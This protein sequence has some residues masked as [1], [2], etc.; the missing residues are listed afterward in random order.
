M[1]RCLILLILVSASLGRSLAG[2]QTAQDAAVVTNASPVEARKFNEFLGDVTRDLLGETMVT[3]PPA[4][5]TSVVDPSVAP[6]EL[7]DALRHSQNWVSSTNL[8]TQAHVVNDRE[9]IRA[10]QLKIEMARRHRVERNTPFAVS[11]LVSVLQAQVPDELK[12]TAL[13]ELALVAQQENQFARAQQIFA[14]YIARYPEDPGVPEVLLRQGLLFRQMGANNLALS[15]FYGVMTSA[16]N[17]KLDRLAYYQRLVLQAQAEIADTY[18]LE[19]EFKDAADLFGRL[20]RQEAVD[21]NKPQIH[22]KLLRCLAQL[23]R[24]SDL[25]A[26]GEEFLRLYPQSAEM[27]EVR[28]LLA[29]SLKKAGRNTDALKQVFLLM[30]SQHSGAEEDPEAWRYWQRRTGNEIANQ[31]YREGDHVNALVI[32][33]NLVELDI[34]A[35]W[36]LPILYQVG[37]VYER[38]GQPQKATE[39]YAGILSREK[40][41][42]DNA[43]AGLKAVVEMAR[44]RKGYLGWYTQ[45]ELSQQA[46]R[47][48]TPAP[49]STTQ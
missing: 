12:R 14:Q 40:E 28:F 47:Q 38:L 6:P 9:V 31:L 35:S 24:H 1:N 22:F 23:D 48:S 7:D 13:L 20:L 41:I 16:L 11:L 19:G 37:L 39:T 21:L 15:K 49:R 10:H 32:Y 36:Q 17:L 25:I 29:T 26:R 46:V 27:S 18:Y 30:Q 8:L 33:L 5:A 2:D 43:G 34:A 42:G 4:V 44:W 3:N 45:A